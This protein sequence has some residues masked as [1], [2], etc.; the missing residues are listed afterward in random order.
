MIRTKFTTESLT[1]LIELM[2]E[3]EAKLHTWTEE[4]INSTWDIEVLIGDYEYHIV[5]TVSNEEDN[6]TN[7]F[8]L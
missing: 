6:D 2:G 3:F 5:V 1:N 7:K 8:E 4:N